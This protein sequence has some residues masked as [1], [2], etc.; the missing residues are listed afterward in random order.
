MAIS[1]ET[2]NYLQK[3]RQEGPEYY[4]YMPD[5]VL[6][7]ELDKKGEAIPTGAIW[8]EE[9]YQMPQQTQKK[10]EDLGF[11]ANLADWWID[12][13]SYD[14]MK[15]AYNRS[16]TGTAEKLLTGE[17]RYNVDESDF[18]ILQDIGA[19][20]VSFLM[21]LDIL[22][23]GAGGFVGG[24]VANAAL[25]KGLF[26]GAQQKAATEVAIRSSQRKIGKT[27]AEKAAEA[28][29]KGKPVGELVKK[30]QNSYM[31]LG[32]KAVMDVLSKG[33]KALYGGIQ[34]A[35]VLSLYEAAITGMNY[36]IEG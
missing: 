26:Q 18:S 31:P 21:P 17:S 11:F 24:K 29:I 6:Y 27:V 33:H 34:Q 8:Q 16:L 20:V 9:A 35:P 13:N 32:D 25:K 12:D 7:W 5:D 14:F 1:Q 4:R 28:G 30:A 15:A 10:T 2:K 22:T 3:A 36:E 23:M 19:S